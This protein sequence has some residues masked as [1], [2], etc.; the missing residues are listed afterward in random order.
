VLA[1]ALSRQPVQEDKGAAR[2][3]IRGTTHSW[4]QRG[5]MT[6]TRTRYDD[7]YKVMDFTSAVICKIRHQKG[8]K[9]RSVH[10]SDLK[11]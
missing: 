3:C 6:M 10:V 4:K 2:L 1:D 9:K 8:R 5:T 7:P 11:N